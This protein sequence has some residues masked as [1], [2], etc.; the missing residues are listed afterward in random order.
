MLIQFPNDH[1]RSYKHYVRR[2]EDV[3]PLDFV[4][5]PEVQEDVRIKEDI[6]VVSA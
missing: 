6:K 5:R 1:R 2:T 3:G 4:E